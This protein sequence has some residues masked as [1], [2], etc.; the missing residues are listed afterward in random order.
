MLKL[1]GELEAGWLKLNPPVEGAA[2]P[3]GCGEGVPPKG[4]ELGVEKEGVEA[5]KLAPNPVW[6]FHQEMT[7]KSDFELVM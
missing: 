5:P 2:W 3:N 1:N 6:Q 4:F 7:D